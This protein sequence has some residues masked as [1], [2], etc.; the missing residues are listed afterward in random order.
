MAEATITVTLK[1]DD[2]V[3]VSREVRV[4]NSTYGRPSQAKFKADARRRAISALNAVFG[5][6]KDV[7]VEGADE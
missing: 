6:P 3:V 2:G 7:V 5:V 4:T 1:R